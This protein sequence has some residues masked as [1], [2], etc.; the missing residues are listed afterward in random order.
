M[1][2]ASLALLLVVLAE[3]APIF[4]GYL[5]VMATGFFLVLLDAP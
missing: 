3:T 5:A 1:V 2:A 4:S